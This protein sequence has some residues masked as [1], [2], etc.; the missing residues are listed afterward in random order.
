MFLLH[1][2]LKIDI[3]VKMLQWWKPKPKRVSGFQMEGMNAGEK[4]LMQRLE[5]NLNR[6]RP[7]IYNEWSG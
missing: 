5:R 4:L 1:K 3:F 7:E 6:E 2:N